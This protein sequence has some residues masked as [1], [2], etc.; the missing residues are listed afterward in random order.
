[1]G[2]SVAQ[3][4]TLGIRLCSFPSSWWCAMV[5]LRA[6][7][8]LLLL[9]S[10]PAF[11]SS[12]YYS[13]VD[14]ELGGSL[15]A[16]YNSIP[17]DRYPVRCSVSYSVSDLLLGDSTQYWAFWSV[18]ELLLGTCLHSSFGLPID[19]RHLLA[20]TRCFCGPDFS[21][22]VI[23]SLLLQLLLFSDFSETRYLAGKTYKHVKSIHMA[24]LIHKD[25]QIQYINKWNH[26]NNMSLIETHHTPTLKS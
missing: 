11:R 22:L 3:Y 7:L 12:T 9:D 16:T 21:T 5:D 1:M 26:V 2:E 19:T 8:L 17:A 25:N 14:L 10:R 20:S 6:G 18:P 4:S 23:L 15:L 13:V 24:Q